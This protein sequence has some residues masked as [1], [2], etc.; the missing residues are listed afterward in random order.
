MGEVCT[1]FVSYPWFREGHCLVVPN[2]HITTLAEI[3]EKE[4]AAI[5]AEL[6]RLAALLDKGYGSGMMQKDQPL[7]PENGIKMDHLHFHVFP[8]QQEEP[9]LFPVPEPNSF[10]GFIRPPEPVVMALAQSLR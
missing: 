5:F 8:R 6:G 9:G 1:S 7:Q 4:A 10:E 3:D 2:R